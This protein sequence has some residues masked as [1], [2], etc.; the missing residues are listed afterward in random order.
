MDWH[1]S[2]SPVRDDENRESDI[3]LTHTLFGEIH[4]EAKS[5]RTWEI[6]WS[7][8][9]VAKAKVNPGRYWLAI[10]T[11]AENHEGSD[12]SHG[13]FWLRNPLEQ[14]LNRD[15]FCRWNW[16]PVD[17]PFS[18]EGWEIPQPG[19]KA[20]PNRF[21]FRI[22]VAEDFLKKFP[23]GLEYVNDWLQDIGPG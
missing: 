4:V 13:V 14:L 17:R 9:E 22:R 21:S 6:F 1:V 18:G 5:A 12:R 2:A 16:S 7:E 19:G 11:P 3:L 10:L 8:L 20:L 23:G 15:R